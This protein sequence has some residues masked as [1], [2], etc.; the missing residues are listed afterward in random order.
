MTE[1]EVQIAKLRQGLSGSSGQNYQIADQIGLGGMSAGVFDIANYP[2]YVAKIGFYSNPDE[3]NILRE[4]KDLNSWQILADIGD[5]HE[6]GNKSFLNRQLFQTETTSGRA[7]RE[8]F[9]NW[10]L[11]NNT[12]HPNLSK[13]VDGPLIQSIG[14]DEESYAVG[15][16]CEKITGLS[17]Y[18]LLEATKKFTSKAYILPALTYSQLLT[19]VANALDF[20]HSEDIIHRDVK[21]TN[22]IVGQTASDL[23]NGY[24][25]KAYLID[26]GLALRKSVTLGRSV[27][28]SPNYMAPE[29]TNASGNASSASDQFSLAVIML[30]ML[31]GSYPLA[32]TGSN[33]EKA[34]SAI[35]NKC[36]YELNSPY[37]LKA[38]LGLEANAAN[39]I[40]EFLKIGIDYIP[41]RRFRTCQVMVG[42]TTAMLE[43]LNRINITSTS[44][45]P[46]IEFETDLER[47]NTGQISEAA[48]PFALAKHSIL[49]REPA[50]L[51]SKLL[52][53][54]LREALKLSLKAKPQLMQKYG[55]LLGFVLTT[56]ASQNVTQLFE[57]IG[58]RT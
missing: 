57:F 10:V 56:D 27:I 26:L 16:I 45:N 34:L 6:A 1:N 32:R 43:S 12:S 31:S 17:L 22:I 53:N 18:G 25:D 46:L 13:I 48:I 49:L 40:F 8:A 11:T 9:I 35:R 21:P 38:K 4:Y 37:L 44:S 30:E 23:R 54:N 20:L 7:L 51:E 33:L 41:D 19:G 42:L 39:I 50:L 29:V 55:E 36:Q 14:D 58:L 47:L 5:M 3:L 2:G 52:I 28:G 15:I 24:G